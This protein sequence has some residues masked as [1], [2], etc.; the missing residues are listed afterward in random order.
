MDVFQSVVPSCAGLFLASYNFAARCFVPG[1][2][3]RWE[4][5]D[6]RSR[7]AQRMARRVVLQKKNPGLEGEDR[8][9]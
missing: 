3:V 1:D 4:K 9:W 7:M 2:A 6:G 8:P 5:V